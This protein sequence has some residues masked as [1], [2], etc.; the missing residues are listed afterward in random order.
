MNWHECDSSTGLPVES[1]HISRACWDMG[2][3][4]LMYG[5]PWTRPLKS[6]TASEQFYHPERGEPSLREPRGNK[7]K[8]EVGDKVKRMG[9][10]KIFRSI[11]KS[12]SL[13]G[14][15]VINLSLYLGI[16]N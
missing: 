5:P 15:A 2:R 4:H 11:N 16:Y 1:G 7:N 9:I 12:H 10:Q 3:L 6:T 13:A 14:K 8:Q